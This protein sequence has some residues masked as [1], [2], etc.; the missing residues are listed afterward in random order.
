MA[1]YLNK[2]E[3]KIRVKMNMERSSNYLINSIISHSVS[4]GTNYIAKGHKEMLKVVWPEGKEKEVKLA[5]ELCVL[6]F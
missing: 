5:S 4:C 1:F 6:T 2:S 3:N